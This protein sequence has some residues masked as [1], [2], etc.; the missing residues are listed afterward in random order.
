MVNINGNVLVTDP[1]YVVPS[2]AWQDF[3]D[4]FFKAGS[5][6]TLVH[7]GLTYHV[8]NTAYGDGKYSIMPSYS[9]YTNNCTFTV[10]SG[11][12]AVIEGAN[13]QDRDV[14]TELMDKGCAAWA[15]VDNGELTFNNVE[16]GCAYVNGVLFVDTETTYTPDFLD[17]DEEDD[18]FFDE[19]DDE[20]DE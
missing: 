2:Y 8:C 6:C 20:E 12:F 13:L 19:G 14:F 17:D 15:K 11:M 16:R 1:C 3:L 9:V 5:P 4:R 7:D 10:D 18:D